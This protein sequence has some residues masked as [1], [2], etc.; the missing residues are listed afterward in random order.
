MSDQKERT[1]EVEISSSLERRTATKEDMDFMRKVHHLA[2]HDVVEKQFGAWDEE[3]QDKFFDDAW[4]ENRYQI[5]L[6]NGVPV[7]Y[8]WVEYSD[9]RIDAHE[10]VILPEFQGQGIGT[11]LLGSLIQEANTKKIPVRLQVLKANRAIDLYKKFGFEEVGE[12]DTHF[13]MEYTPST[14]PEVARTS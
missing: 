1:P 2:Y 13:E 10:L 5:L 4:A 7:G 9:K 12:N 14:S 8:C 11:K 3:K 6:D